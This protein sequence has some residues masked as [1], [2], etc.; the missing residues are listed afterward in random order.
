MNGISGYV[1]VSCCRCGCRLSLGGGVC[2]VY[3]GLGWLDTCINGM[4]WGE[5]C[6]IL[7][8]S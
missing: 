7:L 3:L 8:G 4:E 6:D 5:G 2:L 1:L